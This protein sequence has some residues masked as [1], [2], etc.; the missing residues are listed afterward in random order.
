M[1][2]LARGQVREQGAGAWHLDK[3]DRRIFIVFFC[4]TGTGEPC[5]LGLS[6]SST[7]FGMNGHGPGHLAAALR[8]LGLFFLADTPLATG[9]LG[10]SVLGKFGEL[11]MQQT[12]GVRSGWPFVILCFLLPGKGLGTV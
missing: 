3:R 1:G 4:R 11:G 9:C 7:S 5:L 10:F 12:K 6:F 8:I 2:W